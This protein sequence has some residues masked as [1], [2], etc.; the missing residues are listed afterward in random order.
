MFVG[1][2]DERGV[3]AGR[4]Q[5]ESP[6]SN[7]VGQGS[8]AGAAGTDD[9]N[10]ARIER[11]DRSLEKP[12]SGN[13]Q[14]C[15]RLRRN[16]AGRWFGIDQGAAVGLDRILPER[17]KD[18]ASFYPAKAIEIG[19]CHSVWIMCIAPVQA[20]FRATPLGRELL[21]PYRAPSKPKLTLLCMAG[22]DNI[23]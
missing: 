4:G 17:L 20:R 9:G 11:D 2:A 23:R 8:L 12:G 16:R 19:F 14:L 22:K 10:Q 15:N 3:V 5:S 13:L 6:C 18:R 7:E 21:N 1:A